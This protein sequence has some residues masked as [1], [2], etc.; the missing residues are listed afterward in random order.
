MVQ[1]K[2]TYGESLTHCNQVIVKHEATKFIQKKNCKSA[3]VTVYMDYP[4]KKKPK[5]EEKR[6]KKPP[7]PFKMAE[8]FRDKFKSGTVSKM[9]GKGLL[10]TEQWLLHLGPGERFHAE[11]VA[12]LAIDREGKIEDIMNES[13]VKH[14]QLFH[15]VLLPSALTGSAEVMSPKELLKHFMSVEMRVIFL[16]MLAVTTGCKNVEELKE[17]HKDKKESIP[18]SILAI[19]MATE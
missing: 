12:F 8:F 3:P 19:G 14:F 4:E 10:V 13:L 17:K 2:T 6:P 16:G 11:S 15:S 1:T 9:V 18:S 7:I 5:P